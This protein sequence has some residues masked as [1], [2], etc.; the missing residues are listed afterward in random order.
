MQGFVLVTAPVAAD[1]CWK[2]G[3]VWQ[4]VL[5]VG[6]GLI[7]SSRGVLFA[8]ILFFYP[9]RLGGKLEKLNSSRKP[10]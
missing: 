5:Q 8:F 2:R 7:L 9:Q 10:W 6:D 1:L 3:R 4:K